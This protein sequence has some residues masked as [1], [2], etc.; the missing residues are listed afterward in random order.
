MPRMKKP[1]KESLLLAKLLKRLGSR[2][3]ASVLVEPVWGI[4]GQ[5]TFPGQAGRSGKKSYFK[6]NTLDLNPVGAS[7]IA[8]DKDYA[9]F[10][11]GKM[12][13]PTVRGKSFFSDEWCEAV[14]S[15]RNIHAAYRYAQT[16]GFP[17]VVKPNSGSHGN[18]VF[19]VHDRREFD[20]AMRNIFKQDKVALVQ[21]V[22]SGR[23]YRIVVLDKQ[24]ISAYERIQ[25]NVVGDG[26]STIR[27]LLT[28]KARNFG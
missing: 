14:G 18:G 7:D 15:K 22:I 8:R 27:Q 21:R 9:N 2:I 13:Y 28:K 5:I 26:T 20:A 25:L 6:Y 1:E 4:A 11:M 16:L 24:V 17:V 3:G 19:L 10:F 23:D 12:G